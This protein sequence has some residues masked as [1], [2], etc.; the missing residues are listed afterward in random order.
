MPNTS[1]VTLHLT[2]GQITVLADALS[3]YH[4]HLSDGL[5]RDQADAAENA[6]RAIA[7]LRKLA[8]NG[9]RI[10]A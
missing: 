1:R 2:S 4:E 5:G 10:G 7:I 8:D 9:K 6:G 3:Y